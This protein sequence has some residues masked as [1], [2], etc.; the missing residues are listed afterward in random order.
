MEVVWKGGM[1]EASRRQERNMQNM[2]RDDAVILRE[3]QRSAEMAIHAIDTMSEKVYDD[4]LALQMS[5]QS[6][7]YSEIR[8]RAMNRLLQNRGEPCR[9]SQIR[10]LLQAGGIHTHT[11]L[12][13]STGRIA[14][15][16]IQSSS[17]GVTGLCRALNHYQMAEAGSM[18][19]AREL[20]DFEEKNI[21]L[22]KQYL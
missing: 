9:I 5:R 7:K 19:I 2:K 1:E 6:L 13:V 16:L 21:E 4:S 3:V 22:L 17:R 15:L 18:E 12:D 11:L 8:N 14:E 20:M 10:K